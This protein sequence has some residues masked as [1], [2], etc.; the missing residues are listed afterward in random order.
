MKTI[1]ELRVDDHRLA[2]ISRSL[3]APGRKTN[4]TKNFINFIFGINSKV[5]RQFSS[6]MLLMRFVCGALFL[7][8]GLTPLLQGSVD[9]MSVTQTA[10][11]ASIVLG[12]FTRLVSLTGICMFF[13][14]SYATFMQ[15]QTPE[16]TIVAIMVVLAFF[17]IMGPG[18]YCT[19]QFMRRG[20]IWLSRPRKSRKIDSMSY[21]AYE[22]ADRAV[23]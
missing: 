5:T 3:T 21:K 4:H 12:L 7:W 6:K 11:G 8:V 22:F 19:D 14:S 15:T 13:W 9:M 20:L 1:G 16:Y 2:T 23:S 10:L 17:A 18:R